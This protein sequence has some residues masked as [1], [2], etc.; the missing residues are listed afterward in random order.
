MALSTQRASASLSAES[1]PPRWKHDVFQSFRGADTRRG[2]MSHLDHELRYWQTIKTFKD[3]RDLEIGTTISPELLTA[4]EESHL[5]IIVLSPN[6]ASSTWCLDELSKI[7]ECMEDTKRI[8]PIFYDV[9]PSDVRNQKGSFAEAFTKHEERFS[10]EAE[11]VKRWRAAL[12]EVANLSGLDSKNYK[13]EAELIKN[14]VKCVWTKVHPT[15]MLSGS[16]ENLVGIDF[17]L[18]QLRL[19]LAPEENDVRF[20]GIWGMGGVGKTTLAKLVFEKISHHFELSS[21]LSDVREVSAKHGTLVALQR[22]L[23]FP[24]LKEENIIRVWDEESGIFFTKTYLWNKKVLLILDDVDK[25]NQLEKLVG[26][27]TW[28]GVG[29]RII[30]TTRN[31]RLLVQHDIARRHKV[32]VL[33]NGQ[34]LKLF[35]QHAFKK[36]QSAEGFLE[37]SQ[38]VLHCAKGLPLALK[39]LGTLLY[40]RD[41]DAW[42][43]VLHNVEKIPNP[44][45]LDSLKVSYDGLEEM[46]KKIFLHVACFHKGKDKEK[47]IEILDSIWDISSLIWMD[48][49][50]EKSLLTIKKNNLR[51]DTVEMHDLIQEM[52]WEI[53][54]QESVNEPGKWS[55]LWHTD[56]IS[57]IF[58]NNTGTSAIEAIV[59]SRPKP[60]VVHWN[61]NKAFSK[62]PKLRLLEFD[63]VIFSSGPKVLPNS[64]RIMRWSWYLSESLTPKFYPRFLVKLEMRHSKLVRIWD[65]AKDFPK[66]KYIDLSYSHKLASTPDF[67]RVPVLEELNLKSCTN[68]IEVHG[69]IAVLKRLKR[70]DLSDCKSIKSLPSKVE[71]DSLEY[72]SL[73][74]CSKVKKLPEFEG[75]MKNLFK[76]I[77]NG[78]AVEQIPSSIDGLVGLAVECM[79]SYKSLSGQILYMQRSSKLVK[80]PGEMEC[81]EEL[82]LSESAM[83]ELLVIAMKNNKYLSLHRSSTSR[84]DSAWFRIRK[85]HPDPAPDPLGLVLSSINGLFSL[86]SLDLSDCNI[87]EGVIPDYIGC[88]LYSL[89]RLILRGNNFFS[90]PASIRFLSKLRSLDLSLCERLQQLPDLPSSANLRVNVDDCTSLRRLSDPSNLRGAN[91]YDFAFSCH[92]CF[93]LVEEESWINRIFAMIMR[94]APNSDVEGIVW[95]GSAI[96]EWFSN[97]SVGDSITVELP[98]PP[99]PQSSCSSNWA[100][101]ALCVVLEDSEYLRN[102]TALVEYDYFKIYSSGGPFA[103]FRVGH[104][105]SQHLWV[106][107]IP[108]H[109]SSYWHASSS[110]QFSFEVHYGAYKSS[111][112]LKT[113]SNI[114]K[115]GARLLYERDFEEFCGILKLPKPNLK[116]ALHVAP[117]ASYNH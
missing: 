101:I 99:P 91:V 51:S 69:S 108:R 64:L 9:D 98:R 23:L 94:L 24:I 25:L 110:S 26:E 28:F 7:L 102:Q 20:I 106:I 78:T 1:A 104:L 30:I 49:L 14:I 32:E 117:M 109:R 50:I 76:L 6:Y 96:P 62:T 85:S 16:P 72:F 90:L 44:T 116:S 65:G 15:F 55:C 100:G 8:L 81:L 10:E 82:E 95:P 79:Y 103:T 42:N 80:L 43:S 11:K 18:E 19:Q 17:A 52:A 13:S 41:Q 54:R 31:E 53:I 38:R 105:R 12:R 29:S 61:C 27:K 34:A 74:G 66:L 3:D 92:N 77:L 113:S 39:T 112:R 115:C 68:L 87:G 71:M 46:E 58:M 63:N 75:H 37:L 60:E 36:N 45:V 86:T 21:F 83:R 111:N 67:T 2:F 48:I 57:D 84:D 35:S 89:G 47:I 73:C 5:A 4:I 107:Y 88:C 22:Q 114:K 33:N 40:T 70:L 56:N 97:Q 59:L 93:R